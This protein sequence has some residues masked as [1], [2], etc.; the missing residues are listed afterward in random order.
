MTLAL[1]DLIKETLTRVWHV[2]ILRVISAGPTRYADIRDGLIKQKG[3]SPGDGTIS[4]E[5]RALRDKSLIEQR[6]LPDTRRKAWVLT[7][8]GR[9]A[10]RLVDEFEGLTNPDKIQ[11]EERRFGM[12]IEDLQERAAAIDPTVPHPARRYDYLLGGKDN[13]AAD[14]ESAHEIEAV[15]PTVRLAAMENRGF[16][17]RAVEFLAHQGINQFLDIGTGIPT[18]PN[19]HEVAQAVDPTARV[20]Y[21]D[22]DP[23]VLS[24]ARALLTSAPEGKTAYIDA[25]LRQPSSILANPQLLST[26]DF[27][28]PVGLLLVAVLHFIRDDEDPKG[29]VAALI[30]ALPPGSWVVVSHSTFDYVP[31]KMLPKLQM[32]NRDG[33]FRARSR[34]ELAALLSGLDLVEPGIQSV[35][36]WWAEEAPQPRPAIEDVAIHGAVGR[37]VDS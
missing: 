13:F 36:Q 23:I 12:S 14:R 5:L 29:I 19:T 9:T 15:M 25:D 20:V 34:D 37:V 1:Q 17:Q 30:E 35:S 7:D 26:L 3:H 33:R 8:L 22:N 21:V 32:P 24:H 18:S 4:T 11:A 2:P 10:L 16:L 28:Q 31:V 6:P 27:S